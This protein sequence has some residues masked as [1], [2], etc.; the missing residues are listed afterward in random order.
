MLPLIYTNPLAAGIFLAACLV[1]NVPEWVGALKQTAKASRKEATV[2]D[3]G[4]MGILIGLL[5]FGVA[6]DFVLATFL[7]VTTLTWQR[8][9]LFGLGIGLMLLGVSL[10]WYA[11]RALGRYFTR[12]VAVS[13]N[14][15]VVQS[16]PYHFIRHPAYSGTFLTM[17]GLGLALTN[18]AGLLVLLFCVFLGHLQRVRVEEQALAQTIGQPYI[19]YMRRTKR[20]LPGVY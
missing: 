8:T 2:Q 1:W 14:Q 3:R 10:R 18:G 16:G 19:E 12:E 5:W 20:F 15:Q 7:Q 17:L 9:V 13:A 11:I 6:L 4:S